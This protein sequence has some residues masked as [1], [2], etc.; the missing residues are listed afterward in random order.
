[1]RLPDHLKIF[2]SG[3]FIAIAGNLIFGLLNYLTRRTMAVTLDDIQYGCFYGAFAL[4]SIVLVFVDLGVTDA[5]TALISE[6]PDK[7]KTIFFT[8]WKWKA[9]L[10][11]F[12]ALVLLCFTPL[13]SKKYLHG[14]GDLMMTLLA[15]YTGFQALNGTFVSYT[16]GKKQYQ[17]KS[18]FQIIKVI[19]VFLF[20]WFLTPVWG[21]AGAAA[22]YLLA[23]IIIE[24]CHVLWVCRNERHSRV[25]PFD[26]ELK[27]RTF[28]LVGAVATVTFMQSLILHM[29][30]VMLTALQGPRSTAVYNI[31]SPIT[32]L[33]LSFLVFANVFLPLAVDMVKQKDYGKLR[34]YAFCFMAGT[35]ALLPLVF[36]VMKYSGEYLITLLFKASYAREAATPLLLLMLGFMLFS[37]GSFITQILVAMQKMKTL[38]CISGLTMLVNIA[39]NYFM[40]TA[41]N[42]VGAAGATAL[43]Y[44]FFAS[45]A[46]LF[47]CRHT[48]GKTQ[49]NIL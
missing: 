29:N 36:V 3:S 42:V 44:L 7:R 25:E 40:I 5:G 26:R 35:F 38:L 41:W 39:L 17:I 22:G 20:V 10:G 4:I 21:A 8:L 49:E 23:T 37:A 13:I 12:C 30:S 15:L 11:G 19:F 27:R 34:K 48:Q 47:F 9:L 14:E 1:M 43:S 24:P 2:I 46:F 33:L 6:N 18:L 28:S 31:A 16:T 45:L 32:Q